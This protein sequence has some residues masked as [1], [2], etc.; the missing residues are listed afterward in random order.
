MIVTF[1]SREFGKIEINTETGNAYFFGSDLETELTIKDDRPNEW[2][3][4]D[5]WNTQ[6]VARKLSKTDCIKGNW[7]DVI[8]WHLDVIRPKTLCVVN[9]NGK[10]IHSE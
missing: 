8:H 5:F 7:V 6:F 1:E 4:Q 3:F 10:V 9:G 2:Y